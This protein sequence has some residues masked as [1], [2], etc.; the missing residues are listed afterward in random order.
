MLNRTLTFALISVLT[1]SLSSCAKRNVERIDPNKTT[2]LSGRWNDS[3]SRLTADAMIEQCLQGPWLSNFKQA[4]GGNK[5][6]VIA[7][8]VTNKSHEHIE[9]ETFIKD[10]EK[11]FI[12]SQ[13]VRLVQ[14]GDKREEVRGERADQQ[15]YSSKSSMKKWGL[16]QGADYML[17]GTINSIVDQYEK[18]KTV[19]Y[20][21]DLELTDMETNEVVWI[22]DKKI[23]KFIT[24]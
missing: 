15:N 21:I 22:G 13:K 11:A 23:K 12:T 24:N 9:A 14:G 7:G 3:D 18:K 1:L 17:Q 16:E 8:M 19:T 4:N 20:Q 2:D 10:L 5:P 6:V